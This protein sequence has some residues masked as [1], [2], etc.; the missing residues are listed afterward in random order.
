MRQIRN[1]ERK[2]ICS[3]IVL[4]ARSVST[5][6]GIMINLATTAAKRVTTLVTVPARS[7]IYLSRKPRI[8]TLAERKAICDVIVLRARSV[9]T[10]P[11]T[12]IN[13]ATTA[14]KLVTWCVIAPKRGHPEPANPKTREAASTAARLITTSVTVHP[15][16]KVA[17]SAPVAPAETSL[18]K[19]VTTAERRVTSAVTATRSLPATARRDSPPV[20][21]TS[22]DRPG[23]MLATARTVVA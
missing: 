23:I 19:S 21:A 14:V 18:T 16:K 22:V 6:P 7:S 20:S 13:L 3:V 11:G 15:A 17:K 1:S 5:D 8:A 9:R 4:R 12:M 10:D 2:A